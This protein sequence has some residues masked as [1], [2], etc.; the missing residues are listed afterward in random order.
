MTSRGEDGE[1]GGDFY[2]GDAAC[3]DFSE[4]VCRLLAGESGSVFG[5]RLEEFLQ[6]GHSS[7]V[8][9]ATLNAIAT[10]CR[11]F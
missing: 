11:I 6:R 5:K 1:K 9:A 2:I 4:D 10:P 7:M 8:M 3:E